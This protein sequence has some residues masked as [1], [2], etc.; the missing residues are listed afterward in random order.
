MLDYY[1]YIC[2]CTARQASIQG[3]ADGWGLPTGSLRGGMV[4]IVVV[5]NFVKFQQ[6]CLDKTFKLIIQVLSTFNQV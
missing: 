3:Y 6:V 4:K 5:T 2:S 1:A